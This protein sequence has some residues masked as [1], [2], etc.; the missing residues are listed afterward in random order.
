MVFAPCSERAPSEQLDLGN[1]EL[2]GAAVGGDE[3]TVVR[4][5]GKVFQ[6][7]RDARQTQGT[8][9]NGNSEDLSHQTLFLVSN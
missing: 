2:R 7:A 9:E 6:R 8:V 4:G 5:F 1:L 3:E